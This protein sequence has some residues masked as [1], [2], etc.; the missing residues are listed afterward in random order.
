[1]AER[2][3][4]EDKIRRSLKVYTSFFENESRPE[5]NTEAFIRIFKAFPWSELTLFCVVAGAIAIHVKYRAALYSLIEKHAPW[6]V[7]RVASFY[8]SA[9]VFFINFFILLLTMI[10]AFQNLGKN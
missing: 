5:T 9:A 10:Y 1:L 6:A 8:S 7:G 2:L 4:E 3:K